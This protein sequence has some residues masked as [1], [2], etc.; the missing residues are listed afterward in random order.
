MSMAK[1]HFNIYLFKTDEA[2]PNTESLQ[3]VDLANYNLDDV[4]ERPYSFRLIHHHST[5]DVLA[6]YV[7]AKTTEDS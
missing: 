4:D 6:Y 5:S 1:Y 2:K 7:A 3:F